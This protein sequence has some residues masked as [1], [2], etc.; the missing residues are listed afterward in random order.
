MGGCPSSIFAFVSRC[1]PIPMDL[2]F[3]MPTKTLSHLLVSWFLV[4][5]FT[6]Y[7]ESEIPILRHDPS[8]LPA[9]LTQNHT[10]VKPVMTDRGVALDVDF[11]RADYP[12]VFFTAPAEGW[13]WSAYQGIAVDIENPEEEAVRVN[14]RVDN[15]GADGLNH[16]NTA[17]VSAEPGTVTTLRLTFNTG[18]GK[19][20][21]GMR[22]L[23][24]IGPMGS[25]TPIDSKRI[26][27]FQVFLALPD[28]DHRLLLSSFRLFG[29]GHQPG[30]L[31]EM[32]FIDRFG[33]YKHADWPLKLKEE[34]ELI[35]RRKREQ[36]LLA[37]SRSPQ[38]FDR[39]GGW[40]EGPQLKATGY[41]RTE[42]VNEKWWLVTPEGRLF[43]SIGMDC[44]G[45][46]EFTFVTGR[47]KWFE[48]LP[49][50]NDPA[51][52][53]YHT[54]GKAHSMAEAID[55]KGRTF[56]FYCANLLRKYGEEWRTEWRQMTAN[57]L[58]NWGFNTIGN[59]S[60][61]EICK[62]S[63]IPYVVSFA[64][65][66]GL[67][68]MEGANGYWGYLK[69]V[70][71]PHFADVVDEAVT[72]LAERH[73]GNPLCIGYFSDNELAWE[74]LRPGVLACPP[75][76]PCRI[77]MIQRLKTRYSSL[78]KLNQAWNI[79]ARD[80]DS[81][82]APETPNATATADLDDFVYEYARVYFSTINS[83]LKSRA[84]HQLYLGCRFYAHC[85]PVVRA[86]AESADVVSF[87]VYLPRIQRDACEKAVACGKPV[88]IGE[89]HFGA[90]DRGMFHPGLGP[91][92]D[93]EARAKAYAQYFQSAIDCPAIVGCH[94]FQYVD[95]PVTG[96]W[97]DGENYNIGF[98][99]VTDTPYPELVKSA[100]ETHAELYKRRLE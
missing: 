71:D 56:S 76:Q 66:E 20:L 90:T 2:K 73:A 4:I 26:T 43:F 36:T 48:W 77:A 62:E 74:T 92:R 46:G 52:V 31:V 96:R 35:T 72:P 39:F 95:E 17:S 88:L 85:D 63:G 98:V 89:F 10:S 37:E 75:D 14:V 58:R 15:E 67:R 19:G 23:P 84:P 29:K 34:S 47:D 54:S 57:R 79:E 42:K 78:E 45:S 7:A 9:N 68:N 51:A 83:I 6:A 50:L 8:T 33:Q 13:D 49:A 1:L 81:L 91:V 82:R 87:N 24:E 94:W 12:N 28:R 97:F 41:F 32:P 30:E 40:N 64:L 38:G 53:F 99:D 3:I 70:F 27:A 5:Q 61:G 16:C 21:W 93:Q 59:W 65:G 18:A 25:G 11:F 55:G 100:R 69:D 44:V 22:G 80:W 60:D 86:C